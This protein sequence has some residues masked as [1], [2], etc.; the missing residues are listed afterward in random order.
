VDKL[1]CF[2]FAVGQADEGIAF[3]LKIGPYRVLLDCGLKDIAVLGET[4]PADFVICSHAH[5]DHARGIFALAQAFPALPIYASHTTLRLLTLH[6]AR[7][8]WVDA[9][10]TN[11]TEQ[12]QGLPWRSEIELAAGLSIQLWPAGHLPG[13]ACILLTYQA[14]S[15]PLARA[16]RCLYMGDC[17]LSQMRLVEGLPIEELRGLH[18][19]VLVIEGSYGKQTF[20]HRRQQENRLVNHLRDVLLAKCA[21]TPLGS[22]SDPANDLVKRVPGVIFPVPLL[23]LGQ[24]ILA[25]VRSHHHFTGYP[26]T[27]WVDPLIAVGCDAYLERLE[28]LPK[29]VQNFARYQPLF[30]DERVFPQVKRLPRD[31]SFTLDT[32]AILLVHPATPPE[33]YFHASNADWT[34]FLPELPHEVTLGIWQQEV[35]EPATGYDWLDALKNAVDPGV[36]NLETYFLGDHCDGASTVQLIHNVRSQHVIFLHGTPS[37][38]AAL[39]DLDDLQARYQLHIAQPNQALDL[40]VGETPWEAPPVEEAVYEGMLIDTLE[41]LLIELPE[42]I[43]SDP[44]WVQL[45]DTGI[46]KLRWQGDSLVVQGISAADLRMN[47]LSQAATQ[48]ESCAIC[49]YCQAQKCRNT[50]SP[51]FGRNVAPD[52]HCAA[53]KN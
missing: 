46:L 15:Q 51:L 52:G 37:S 26:M 39:A 36:L 25:L 17:F 34:V 1:S 42:A 43:K 40:F 45:A 28:D 19:D 16:Y 20:P 48:G 6:P 33:R 29:P 53:F 21:E 5:E 50:L 31:G 41:E 10:E 14:P 4:Q 2:S 22:T 44:R 35:I 18:P 27:I 23:G 8:G 38:L 24:E 11:L 32:P 7:Q 30:W 3:L 49:R 12:Y 47:R 9:S 13:A